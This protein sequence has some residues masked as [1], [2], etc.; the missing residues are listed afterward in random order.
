MVQIIDI[1]REWQEK[2]NAIHEKQQALDKRVDVLDEQL[3]TLRN[4]S[5]VRKLFNAKVKI[6]KIKRER[7]MALDMK[8]V[9]TEHLQSLS[10]EAYTL[11]G[12][13]LATQN[14]DLAGKDKGK[15]DKSAPPADQEEHHERRR[16]RNA[17]TSDSLDTLD[18]ETDEI[19]NTIKTTRS[20]LAKAL[21][22]ER[23]DYLTSSPTLTALSWSSTNSAIRATKYCAEQLDDF[24]R[25]Y[26]EEQKKCSQL[27]IEL[28]GLIPDMNDLMTSSSFDFIVGF[29][30]EDSPAAA[31]SS[32][33]N[34]NMLKKVD[35][36]LENVAKKLE[37]GR[38][39]IVAHS[40]GLH[41]N[42]SRFNLDG[43]GKGPNGSPAI[44]KGDNPDVYSGI[45]EKMAA[46]HKNFG[47]FISKLKRHMSPEGLADIGP[48]PPPASHHG[49]SH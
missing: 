28:D 3:D 41:R 20:A 8:R 15:N 32:L 39:D 40:Q 47:T 27:G 34:L 7:E 6:P 11:I 38:Q 46:Q 4:A 12:K 48:T 13:T 19:L 30:N 44:D 23:N 10:D 26:K 45:V 24:K 5:G 16:H 1:A 21:R 29:N 17:E 22:Q 36:H 25:V 33:K 42:G 14:P 18:T 31:I 37:E 49:H 9:H 43:D 2:A 35:S